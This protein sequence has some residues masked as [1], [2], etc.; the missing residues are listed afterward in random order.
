MDAEQKLDRRATRTRQAIRTALLDMM[1]EAD[2]DRVSIKDL[3]KRAGIGYATF[4]RHYESKDHLMAQ[5]LT[6]LIDDLDRRLQPGMTTY[7]EIL[8][9]YK[10]VQEKREICLAALKLPRSNQAS[11]VAWK[12]IDALALE[13]F[14]ARKDWKIPLDVSINHLVASLWGVIRWWLK[15]GEHY[16]PEQIAAFHTALILK[17]T[18]EAQFDPCRQ[19]GEESA[20]ILQLRDS[21][22]V[23]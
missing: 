10:F 1:S 5:I 21:L 6:E 20:D 9:L 23:R 3:T 11:I 12:R 22:F 2:Y 4:F 17:Q 19:P 7:E 16:S 15:D 13:R 8:T 14:M 18:R